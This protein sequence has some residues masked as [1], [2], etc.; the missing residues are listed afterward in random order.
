MTRHCSLQ[1][2]LLLSVVAVLGLHSDAMAAASRDASILERSIPQS[3]DQIAV[4]QSA[5]TGTGSSQ[6]QAKAS[7]A[8]A[9]P[10]TQTPQAATPI[11]TAAAPDTH[12]DGIAASTPSGAAIAPGKQRRVRKFTIRTALVVG[13]IVA[14]GI[15]SA[16]SLASPARP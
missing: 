5:N 2:K 10:Q 3:T 7:D 1:C 4:A 11:G 6:T 8:V 9:V 13:A 15:V 16:V 12:V 14:V